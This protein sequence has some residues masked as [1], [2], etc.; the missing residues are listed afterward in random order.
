MPVLAVRFERNRMIGSFKEVKGSFI[1]ICLFKLMKYFK[2]IY[3]DKRKKKLSEEFIKI[4]RIY[5]DY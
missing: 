1:G 3:L 2:Y 5:R 4:S